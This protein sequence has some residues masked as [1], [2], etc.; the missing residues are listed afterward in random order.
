[1]TDSSRIYTW[2]TNIFQ[3]CRDLL[4]HEFSFISPTRHQERLHQRSIKASK[5]K[6]VS[7]AYIIMQHFTSLPIK[8]NHFISFL[9]ALVIWKTLET[10]FYSDFVRSIVSLPD[11][12][13]RNDLIVNMSY[14]ENFFAVTRIVYKN[15]SAWHRL[16]LILVALSCLVYPPLGRST[17]SFPIQGAVIKPRNRQENRKLDSFKIWVFYSIKLVASVSFSVHWPLWTFKEEGLQQPQT[18]RSH[19]LTKQPLGTCLESITWNAFVTRTSLRL[20]FLILFTF[21]LKRRAS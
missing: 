13:K 11:M 12:Q 15:L 18:L 14:L 17:G 10:T 7:K 3:T 2:C 19:F 8:G 16:G 5:N 21:S 9:H 4:I 20:H 1:M 6:F